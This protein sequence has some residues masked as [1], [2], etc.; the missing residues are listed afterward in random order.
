[1]TN[2]ALIKYL[3]RKNQKK[4]TSSNVNVNKNQSMNLAKFTEF[5]TNLNADLCALVFLVKDQKNSN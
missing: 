3:R 1:M 4:T 2:E 5:L